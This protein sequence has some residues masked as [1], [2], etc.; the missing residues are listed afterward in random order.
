MYIYIYIYIPVGR[1]KLYY[2]FNRIVKLRANRLISLLSRSCV[3][4]L[5][6]VHTAS[7]LVVG[8]VCVLTVIRANIEEIC[9]TAGAARKLMCV[10]VCVCLYCIRAYTQIVV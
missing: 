10:C 3:I 5:H 9:D 6:N 1:N 4:S 7:W 2:L 8:L